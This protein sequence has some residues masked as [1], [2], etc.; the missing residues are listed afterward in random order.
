[1]SEPVMQDSLVELCR[2]GDEDAARVLVDQYIDRLVALARR[3]LKRRLHRRLDAEDIV[4]SVFRT[5]FG[6]IKEGQFQIAS[7][8]DLCKLLMRITVHKTLRLVAYHQA[9]KRA[10]GREI[11]LGG[12]T[13]EALLEVIGREPSPAAAA[14]FI[15]QLE[16][17]LA[18]LQ[19]DERIILEMKLQDYSNAEIAAALKTYDRKIRRVIERIRSL[20]A[21]EGI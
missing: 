19:P 2:A 17:F 14:A 8:D 15:D 6:R 3:R 4:Q 21:A 9:D 13:P 7:Q 1:M 12:D 16:Q 10:A 18:K 20:A 11:E 5:F